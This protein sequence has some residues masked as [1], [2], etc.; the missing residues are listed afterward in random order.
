M[1]TGPRPWSRFDSSTSARAGAFGLARELLDLGDEQDRLEQLVDADAGG[2]RDVDDDRVA[3]PRL[4]HELAARR[5]A[6]GRGRVGV[7]AVDLGDRHDDRHLGR[8]RVV[9]RLDRLRHHAV[10][11]RDHE[12]RDVGGVGAAGAHRGER[13]VARR[14][15]EGDRV[16]V[17]HR[18]VGADVLGDATRLAGDDVRVTDVVEQRGL[19]V[20]DVA[21]AR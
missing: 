13:L 9:D 8:T 21:H 16:A 17:V 11:G 6:G 7:L 2:R 5:A 20:V 10:V 15:D 1:T 18:L 4:G 3:T 14:V 12:D 19:A